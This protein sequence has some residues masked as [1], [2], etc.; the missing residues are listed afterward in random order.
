M[1]AHRRLRASPRS[2]F[3]RNRRR[4]S[5]LERKERL[6]ASWS[7]DF[8]GSE[9]AGAA[10]S[11]VLFDSTVF[12]AQRR[13]TFW[14]AQRLRASPRSIFA[15]KWRLQAS[16]SSVFERGGG[17]QGA[18]VSFSS[19][20]GGCEGAGAANSSA[21]SVSKRAGA[22]ILMAPSELEQ[23]IRAHRRPGA[24]RAVNSSVL[25]DSTVFSSCRKNPKRPKRP[26]ARAEI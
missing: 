15:R 24:A 22:A 4:S 21:R 25:F 23:R 6:Q 1:R 20:I 26:S 14:S 18:R 3:E 2:I 7:S 19:A 11:S 12:V 8:D 9:R 17:S 10:N 5:K 16:S 13:L